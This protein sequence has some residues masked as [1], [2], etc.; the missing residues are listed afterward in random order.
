MQ[1]MGVPSLVKIPHAVRQL[2]L[3]TASR[4]P[5]SHDWR[6]LGT[7]EPVLQNKRSLHTATRDKPTC[8]HVE[9]AHC[10]KDPVQPKITKQKTQTNILTN[11]IGCSEL[12]SLVSARCGS[13]VL[14]FKVLFQLLLCKL[15]SFFCFLER[16][17]LSE[18]RSSHFNFNVVSCD[19]PSVKVHYHFSPFLKVRLCCFAS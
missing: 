12:Q 3:C 8:C 5:M 16:K 10:S 15:Q 6:S 19:L 2:S 14:V 18:L 1:G 7:L 4:K 17:L 9:P 13:R 11:P